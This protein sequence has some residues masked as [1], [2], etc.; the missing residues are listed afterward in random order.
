MPYNCV[1]CGNKSKQFKENEED[2]TAFHHR[3]PK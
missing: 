2:F 1:V 3:Q